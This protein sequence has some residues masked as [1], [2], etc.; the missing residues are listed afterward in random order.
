[1][2]SIKGYFA[3]FHEMEHCAEHSLV[4]SELCAMIEFVSAKGIA[5]I[6]SH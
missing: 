5:S 3:V 1:M 4:Q 6:E 2:N